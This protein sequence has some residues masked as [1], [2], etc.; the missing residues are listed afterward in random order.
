VTD[1]PLRIGVLGAARIAD[2]ALIGPAR[3]TGHRVV[4][5]A[6]R[7]RDRAAAFAERHGVERVL[8]SYAD[9]VSDPEV[10]VVYNPLANALHGPWNLAAIR[11]GKHVLSEK[12]FASDAAEAALVRD[13]AVAAGVTVVE[14]FHYLHHPVA[15]RLMALLESGELGE[16]TAVD[17]DMIMPEPP[18]DDPRWMLDLAG[19]GL[20]DVGCYGLHFSRM[21]GRWAGGEPQVVAATADE[22]T[23]QP[24]VDERLTAELGYP[25]GATARVESSMVAD[26]VRF[27]ARV[28]GTRGSA[29]AAY[30]VK[31]QHDDRVTI[32]TDD[33]EREE[34]PGQR[35]SYE[36][37]LDALAAHL[38]EG[39]PLPFDVDDAVTQMRLVD[40]CYL[41]AG[42]PVRPRLPLPG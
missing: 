12:P 31:P 21:L 1:E 20:M 18:D 39:R 17:I 4:A 7:D 10:E 16:L 30:F 33:G 34:H 40:A 11:A 27:S 19:G 9:L 32:T 8:D 37:Q 6:A 42:L 23:G 13:A 22:R 35:P 2:E 28:T 3:A 36:F 24:G 14:A 38:R 26:V 15:Q 25:S 41:A 5:V 29:Y